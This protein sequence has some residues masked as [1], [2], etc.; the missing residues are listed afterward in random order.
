MISLICSTVTLYVRKAYG[1]VG[2]R[3]ITK[4]LSNLGPIRKAVVFIAT[5]EVEV[6]LPFC[7]EIW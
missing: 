7:Y 5:L 3:A 4:A 1:L 2:G 6:L